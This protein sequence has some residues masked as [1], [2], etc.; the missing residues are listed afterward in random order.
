LGA[1]NLCGCRGIYQL[2]ERRF[3]FH[4]GATGEWRVLSIAA[5]S[6]DSLAL[7]SKVRIIEGFD[8]DASADW[9]LRGVTS[10]ERY[11]TGD[12]RVRLAS[13]QPQLGR[14]EATRAALIPIKKNAEWWA[15]PQDVRRAI[16]EERS[17]HIATGMRYLPAVARRLHHCYDIGEP[18]DFLTWF[19]YAPPDAKAFEELVALLRST[20]EWRYVIREVDIRLER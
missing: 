7:V 10:Y 4:G 8:A 5:V 15:L 1:G 18:F 20:E 6:G 13:V 17:A 12:E 16:F 9:S 2:M 11:V 19:E 3:S 14:V